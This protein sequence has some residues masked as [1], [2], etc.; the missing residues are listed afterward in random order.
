MDFTTEHTNDKN[1]KLLIW[2]VSLT[3]F[4][5]LIEI[6]YGFISGS[7]MIIG[8]G[9]H[10]S[11]DAMSLI[12]SLIA[13]IMATKAV[14]KNRT[15]GFK[16]FEP[17]AAFING[18]VLILIPLYITY[19]AINR[20]INPVEIIAEQMIVVGLIGLIINGLVGYIL[21]KG[22][23]N[24]NMRSAL[25]H[26][27]ADMITSLSAVIVA[28]AVMFFDFVW[29]DPLGSIATSIIIIRGGM[30][31]T[32]ESFNIL[33]EG[34]PDGYSVERIIKTVQEMN[35]DL[36]VEDV[37]VWCVNEE[38]VYTLIRVK[39]TTQMVNKVSRAIKEIVSDSSKIP[40]QNIYV[41]VNFI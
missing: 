39:A 33:M 35:K 14:T 38:D 23:S 6:V 16:R 2:A 37:K 15:F 20:M 7:L 13:A 1:K 10:M 36:I 22:N 41:D 32:R 12:L 24:L 34:T 9:I 25:L 4:F 8:D 11:S 3:S 19:E 17:I 29:L 21:S 26:V 31:I 40:L 30:K 28:L 27:F 18:L 5:A